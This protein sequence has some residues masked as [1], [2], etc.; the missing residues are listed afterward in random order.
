MM[1]NMNPFHSNKKTILGVKGLTNK[2]GENNCFL[3]SAIQVRFSVKFQF[4]MLVSIFPGFMEI[5]CIS[6]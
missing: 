6:R 5:R 3:N 2:P 4:R 1:G